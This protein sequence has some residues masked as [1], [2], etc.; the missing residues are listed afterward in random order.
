MY[1]N[2]KNLNNQSSSTL[3][4]ISFYH[5]YGRLTNSPSGKVPVASDGLAQ[6]PS[7]PKENPPRG[8]A[9]S[10]FYRASGIKSSRD[11]HV[12]LVNQLEPQELVKKLGFVTSL[13]QG[14]G[15]GKQGLLAAIQDIL[16][17]SVNTWDQGFLD[18]LYASTNAVRSALPFP[19]LDIES[20]PEA[21]TR[22]TGRRNIRTSSLSIEHK[23]E[24]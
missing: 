23:C 2:D 20:H 17:Y 4:K 10:I 22:E 5:G 18:K 12:P 14:Q 16:H 21:D 15:E 19:S 1:S 13:P 3:S 9:D 8:V 7:S 11:V 6:L 24:P